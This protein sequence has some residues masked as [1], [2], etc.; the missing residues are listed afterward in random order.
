MTQARLADHLIQ[1]LRAWGITHAQTACLP[2]L[3]QEFVDT[4]D[5]AAPALA[6]DPQIVPANV[7]S[8]LVCPTHD[9]A[10]PSLI[11]SVRFPDTGMD[12]DASALNAAFDCAV[13]ETLAEAEL[14]AF[15]TETDLRDALKQRLARCHGYRGLA[16]PIYV[17]AG[18][19]SAQP[20]PV[21]SATHHK[22]IGPFLVD[23]GIHGDT[24][25]TDVSRT[26]LAPDASARQRRIY[27]L[28]LKA[29]VRASM[30]TSAET[31]HLQ[32]AA[33][34][35]LQQDGYRM[36]H[37]LGHMV[38]PGLAVHGPQPIFGTQTTTLPD[39]THFTLEP[40]HYTAGDFGVRLENLLQMRHRSPRTLT[41][42][43]LDV[44]R[45]YPGLLTAAEKNWV[46]NYNN[47]CLTRRAPML[48]SAAMKWCSNA[49]RWPDGYN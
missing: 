37:G 20:H 2:A 48:S 5:A 4:D 44:R 27:T 24:V 46:Q 22:L 47:L 34:P 18:H 26:L 43:P 29:L 14:G 21:P 3:V 32:S 39:G 25:T 13:I 31:E 28:V 19:R 7:R 10:E 40:G 45:T 9:I 36:P 17:A 33:L 16:F 6:V 38:L 8:L 41:H 23:A 49:S 15:Q 35:I 1:A 12:I 30:T 11:A 42:I